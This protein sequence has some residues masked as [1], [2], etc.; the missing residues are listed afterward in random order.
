MVRADAER[1]RVRPWQVAAVTVSIAILWVLAQTQ[2]SALRSGRPLVREFMAFYTVGYVLNH[3]PEILYDPDS[4][5][6]TYRSLFPALPAAVKQLY[7]H[8]PFE[9]L[10][11][12][13]FALLPFT[14]ALV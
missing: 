11:F 6:G 3:S 9:A 1:F 2:M 12:R 13:P 10:A 7:A 5:N 8:A 14:S 4:F